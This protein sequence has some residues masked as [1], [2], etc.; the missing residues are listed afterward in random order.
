MD[1]NEPNEL[2]PALLA[3]FKAGEPDAVNRVVGLH[4]VRVAK[5]ARARLRD[6]YL[7]GS[8]SQDIAASVF[9]SLI[10]RVNEKE[11]GDADLA[12]S[13]ELW[14]LLCVM[15]RFKTEDHVRR[16]QAAKRGGGQLRGESVLLGP[17][18]A[19]H[20]GINGA[21]DHAM[22]PSEEL[23][24]KEQHGK[25]MHALEDHILQE[26]ATLRLEGYQVKEIAERFEKSQRWA[27]RKLALIRDIWSAETDDSHDGSPS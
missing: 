22:S 4:F 12:S 20:D 27:K 23:L 24:L 1:V 19:C 15:I 17:G 18:D 14:R 16:E 2:E 7:R 9:E 3:R 13:D 6:R 11:F 21:I 25:L 26:V 8:D 5:A 10:K